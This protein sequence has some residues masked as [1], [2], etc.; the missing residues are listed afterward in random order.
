MKTSWLSRLAVLIL[1]GILGACSSTSRSLEDSSPSDTRVD[2]P[3][4][5]EASVDLAAT[6]RPGTLLWMVTLPIDPGHQAGVIY[7]R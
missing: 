6:P 4:M 7:S 2:S 1:T 5:K 3:V